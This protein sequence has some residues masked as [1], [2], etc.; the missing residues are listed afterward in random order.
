[1][2][3]GVVFDMDGVL[4]D[5]ERISRDSW[6][7]TAERW[8]I[9]GIEEV[10]VRVI[11]VNH[12]DGV[13]ILHDA[14]GADFDCE[15][16][17]EDCHLKMEEMLEKDGIPVKAG[18]RELLSYLKTNHYP[19]AICSSTSV[20]VILDHLK[21]TGLAEYF[22]QIVGGNMVKHSKPQPDIYLKA[23]EVLG[24]KPEECLAI[25][26][27]PNGIRAASRAGLIPV[28]VP[29]LVAPTE[30]L[31][32]LSFRIEKDLLKVK[33]WLESLEQ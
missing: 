2:I 17:M 16:F 18:V 24:Q 21:V 23:C 14:Y 33:A 19:V 4:F 32:Q 9:Q 12:H 3:R 25:E 29:D 27:S 30:E 10:Y 8:G 7:F 6:I 26:D 11:G 15:R 1:M 5:T 13:D 31:R 28:M 22:D 20:P